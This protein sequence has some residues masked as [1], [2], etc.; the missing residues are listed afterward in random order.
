MEASGALQPRED[1]ETMS[2]SELV[3]HLAVVVP[4]SEEQQKLL[5]VG[6]QLASNPNREIRRELAN[7]WG[8]AQKH[9]GKKKGLR[10]I[11]R[12]RRKLLTATTSSP[13][14]G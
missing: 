5:D 12:N 1:V 11:T 4:K 7:T 8:V 14:N 10:S 9:A 2:L 13:S 6:K 3:E